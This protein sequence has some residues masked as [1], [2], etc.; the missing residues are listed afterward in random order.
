MA[1]IGSKDKMRSKVP[2]SSSKV[3]QWL[4]CW[5]YSMIFASRRSSGLI[6]LSSYYLCSQGWIKGKDILLDHDSQDR[7]L[8]CER[9]VKIVSRQG[10][11]LSSPCLYKSNHN[12][13]CHYFQEFKRGGV[14]LTYRSSD[15]TG[16][17]KGLPT[18]KL[19]F[20]VELVVPC[21]IFYVTY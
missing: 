14:F 8:L 18:Q 3:S 17:P 1:A 6:P 20:L 16:N 10:F 12:H 9:K 15:R 7:N 13:R 5:Q 11:A 21:D 2:K 19:K 4:G